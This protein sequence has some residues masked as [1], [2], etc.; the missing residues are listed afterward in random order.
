MFVAMRAELLE[1]NAVSRVPTIFAGGVARDAGRSLVRVGAALC[2]LQ[3]DDNTNTFSHRIS[4]GMGNN[5]T[6]S[7]I[8]SHALQTV[9]GIS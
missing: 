5:K 7:L 9:Q 1:F 4:V 8:I 2:A 3:R 6:Q